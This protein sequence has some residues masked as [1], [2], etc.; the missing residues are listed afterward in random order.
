MKISVTSP[1]DIGLLIRAV[2]RSSRVRIDDLAAMSHV[3]KQFASDVE[4]G[5]PTVRLGLVFKLL[6]ELGIPM[7]LDIP[8]EAVQELT[9]LRLRA[10]A[11]AGKRPK[12]RIPS[13]G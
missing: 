2:R 3:S 7:T 4:H 5:K 8:S 13:E 1:E 9:T 12:K 10:K 6:G 11:P